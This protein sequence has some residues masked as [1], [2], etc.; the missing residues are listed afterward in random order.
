MNR[1]KILIIDDEPDIRELLFDFLEN[2]GYECILA[3]DA[4]DALKKFKSVGE[5]DLVMSD[6]RM[7]GKSGLELLS[8]LKEIDNDV[9]VIMI[10]AVKDIQSAISAMSNGAYDYIS[11]PFKLTEVALIAKKAIEKRKLIL[12]NKEYQKKL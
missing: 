2:D 5:I 9:I 3:H 10:S 8:E 6:I 11:K 12:E 7:P 1:S 4:F